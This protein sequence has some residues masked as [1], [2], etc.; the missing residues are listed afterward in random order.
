MTVC[1]WYDE[2]GDGNYQAQAHSVNQQILQ[3]SGS[4]PVGPKSGS[5]QCVLDFR[6]GTNTLHW[7]LAAPVPTAI[8]ASVRVVDFIPQRHSDKAC[9]FAFSRVHGALRANATELR[10]KILIVENTMSAST[11]DDG[12]P[13]LAVRSRLLT[14]GRVVAMYFESRD[15]DQCASRDRSDG[16]SGCRAHPSRRSARSTPEV[17][18]GG[19][20]TQRGP[21]CS[22]ARRVNEAW[23]DICFR[24]LKLISCRVR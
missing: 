10:Q 24:T 7:H 3:Y 15:H 2:D 19:T 20:A 21:Q 9:G 11:R 6:L 14:S 23:Y 1:Q 4:D 16:C 5:P 22:S 8:A 18:Y 12:H 17:C 13:R